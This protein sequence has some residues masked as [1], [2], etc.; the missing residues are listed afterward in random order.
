MPSSWKSILLSR[1]MNVEEMGVM[2]SSMA[3]YSKNDS[4]G[5]RSPTLRLSEVLQANIKTFTLKVK[6][7]ILRIT[8]QDDT[9]YYQHKFNYSRKTQLI[10]NIEPSQMTVQCDIYIIIHYQHNLY[11]YYTIY[12]ETD[13]E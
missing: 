13:R 8:L 3:V 1:T 4:F 11:I 7:Q 12:L 9:I 10:W 5:W 2:T 6:I